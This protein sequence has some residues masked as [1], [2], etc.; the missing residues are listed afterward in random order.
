MTAIEEVT[1]NAAS[2]KDR[3]I[4]AC[5]GGIVCGIDDLRERFAY[6][7]PPLPDLPA[8]P[9]MFVKESVDA[10]SVVDLL[11]QDECEDLLAGAAASQHWKNSGIVKD[12]IEQS[13]PE[14]RISKTLFEQHDRAPFRTIK[15]V[16]RTRLSEVLREDL[17]LTH[18]N[19][20]HY[21]QGGHYVA[22][23]DASRNAYTHRLISCIC[24]LT[25]EYVGGY[26]NFP[27]LGFSFK[28]D[29]GTAIFF[30]SRYV[31]SGQ[32]L[33]AGEKWILQFFLSDA[34]APE[35]VKFPEP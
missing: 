4:L 9:N 19:I 5:P 6:P 21:S 24:Y 7:S 20:V 11:T 10:L 27:N 35:H 12:G 34:S 2:L 8:K 29:R 26:T 18:L 30:P 31:H 13:T 17:F 32:P 33:D 22:H 28:G 23:T 3:R 14:I 15:H 16:L 1:G 25:E